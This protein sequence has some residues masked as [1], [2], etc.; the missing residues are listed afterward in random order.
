M[1]AAHGTINGGMIQTLDLDM[2]KYEGYDVIITVLDKMEKETA[3]EKID[4]DEFVIPND[5]GID[6]DKYVRELR[7]SQGANSPCLHPDLHLSAEEI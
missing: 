4:L 6:P 7:E 2:G 1:I 5:R 3:N